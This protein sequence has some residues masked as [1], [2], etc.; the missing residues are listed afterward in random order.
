MHQ[1]RD[2]EGLSS[3]FKAA[4]KFAEHMIPSVLYQVIA[5]LQPKLG[6]Q[7]KK[8]QSFPEYELSPKVQQLCSCFSF[9]IM[10]VAFDLQVVMSVD[11]V[12]DSMKYG[13]FGYL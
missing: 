8:N 2:H 13:S 1:I 10:M 6:T 5:V 9:T 11:Y 7:N 3:C 12:S 4:C